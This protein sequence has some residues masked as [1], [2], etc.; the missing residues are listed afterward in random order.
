MIEKNATY[1][2]LMV[3]AIEH[4]CRGEEVK[5]LSEYGL[6]SLEEWEPDQVVLNRVEEKEGLWVAQLLLKDRNAPFTFIKQATQECR[7]QK[8][9]EIVARY[10]GRLIEESRQ[11]E[12]AEEEEDYFCWN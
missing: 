1:H 10:T 2:H 11:E 5:D 12:S 4:Y 6:F 3:D 9:A 7:T 8:I